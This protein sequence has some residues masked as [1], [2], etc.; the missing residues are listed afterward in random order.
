MKQGRKEGRKEGRGRNEGTKERRKEFKRTNF[1]LSSKTIV[2][3][4]TE[5]TTDDC[6]FIKR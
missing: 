2:I 1:K 6:V 4:L 5:L 3:V